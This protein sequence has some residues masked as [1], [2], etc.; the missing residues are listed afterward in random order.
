MRHQHQKLIDRDSLCFE[1]VNNEARVDMNKVVDFGEIL[2]S[3]KASNAV[4]IRL[5]GD[6]GC[7]QSEIL[8]LL[9]SGYQVR[10]EPTTL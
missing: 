8:N 3:I 4:I 6:T 2:E 1:L 9:D 10:L 5:I 7:I